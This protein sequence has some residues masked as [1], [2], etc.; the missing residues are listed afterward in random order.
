MIIRRLR[1]EDTCIYHEFVKIFNKMVK[2]LKKYRKAEDCRGMV[3]YCITSRRKKCAPNYFKKM[4]TVVP[5]LA[6]TADEFYN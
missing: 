1:L 6:S 3:T 5:S 4:Q 2:S